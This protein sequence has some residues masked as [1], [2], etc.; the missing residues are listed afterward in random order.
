M[1][2]FVAG[3]RHTVGFCFL[4]GESSD[5]ASMASGSKHSTPEKRYQG[6]VDAT[7]W[8]SHDVKQWLLSFGLKQHIPTFC[9]QHNMDGPK[10]MNMDSEGLKSLGVTSSA[11]RAFMKKKIKELRSVLEKERRSVE[12]QRKVQEKLLKKSASSGGSPLKKKS[13]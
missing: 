2:F 3:R 9:D 4:A 13:P 6:T 1:V 8:T 7:D 5:S 10:L 12:K 11:E